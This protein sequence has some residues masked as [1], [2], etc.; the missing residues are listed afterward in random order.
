MPETCRRTSGVTGISS[1]ERENAA[2]TLHDPL[3]TLVDRYRTSGL[4]G[5]ARRT[6]YSS[7]LIDHHAPEGAIFN[8]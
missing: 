2:T 5:D 7:R 4:S 1:E 3:V 8:S 6:R